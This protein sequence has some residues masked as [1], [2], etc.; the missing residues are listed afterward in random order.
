MGMFVVFSAC[1]KDSTI[2]N[3]SEIMTDVK[4]VATIEN[5]FISRTELQNSKDVLWEDNDKLSVFLGNTT[6]QEFILETGAGSTYGTFSREGK[7]TIGGGTETDG[8]NF[9]NVAYYPYGNDVNIVQ[10]GSD[11]KISTV[12]P[13]IQIFK[14]NSFGKNISPMVALSED[15]NFPFKNIGGLVAIPLKGNKT[16]IRATVESGSKKLAGACV[17]TL[18]SLTKIPTITEWNNNAENKITIECGEGIELSDNKAVTF[19]FVIPP[20]EYEGGDLTYKFYDTEGYYMTYVAANPHTVGRN[21]YVP[22]SEKI[23]TPGTDQVILTETT[24]K[25]AILNSANTS[26][27]IVIEND[28][29]L[30][31]QLVVSNSTTIDLNGKVLSVSG[32]SSTYSSRSGEETGFTGDA[33]LVVKRGTTLTIKD[34]GNGGRIDT[35]ENP[36]LMGAIKMTELGESANGETASLIVEGGTIKGYYYGIMGNGNRH[37]TSIEIKGGT[38]EA[39]CEDDNTGIFHPQNGTLTISGGTV[40][41]Y[42][43]AVEMRA[44]TLRISG[45]DFSAT[46]TPLTVEGNGSGT[47]TAGAAIAVSQHSTNL[48][49]KVEITGGEFNGYYAL[50]EKDVQDNTTSN[51]FMSVN[52]GTFN[53]SIA[54]EN[55]AEFITGGTFSNPSACSYLGENANV[56]I[57]M[58]ESYEG[59]GFSTKS[60]QTV[61][62]TMAEGVVY[63]ATN[64]LVGSTGTVSQSFQFLQGSNVTIKGGKLTSSVARMFIQNYA[65]LTLE[66]VEIEPIIPTEGLTSDYYYVLSNNCGTIN[67]NNGTKIIAPTSTSLTV[68]AMDVCKY[69]NYPSVTVNVNNGASIIGNVEYSGGLDTDNGTDTNQKLYVNQGAII[70]GNL[71]VCTG[72]HDAALRGIIV[73]SGSQIVGEGWNLSG[74]IVESLTTVNM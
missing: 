37:D 15:F 35:G 32:N 5:E 41:G 60:G 33:L 62:V 2:L 12:F 43:T 38:I 55:C 16:I 3:T 52:G 20:A 67:L 23:Y 28:I 58:T 11:Y 9:E 63:N 68:F 53:G 69:L 39:Y 6:N 61:N 66:D 40:K 73:D 19:V 14:E 29:E 72:C 34:S 47:T 27:P 31:E 7:V 10:D 36:A 1:Q 21:Q 13:A 18:P 51:I 26:E 45:G 44:G 64:P 56:T 48:D 70:N 74:A 50:N 49:L 46:A 25:N 8:S 24:L 59:P 57:Y 71:S 65:D 4:I 30:S 54:S 17:V 22:Y 42:N